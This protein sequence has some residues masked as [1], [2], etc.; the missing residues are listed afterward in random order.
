MQ[1]G[2]LE[3]QVFGEVS[4]KTE[5][6]NQG[7]TL[8][9][10]RLSTDKFHLEKQKWGKTKFIPKSLFLYFKLPNLIHFH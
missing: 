10:M 6:I 2:I 7:K 5:K 3:F 4:L 1:F 9:E 8:F